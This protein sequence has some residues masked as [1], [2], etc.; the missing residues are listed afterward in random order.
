[1]TI[2]WAIECAPSGTVT[3]VVTVTTGERRVTKRAERVGLACVNKRMILRQAFTDAAEV[4]PI[5]ARADA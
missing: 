5:E 1:M 3:D 2:L 4:Y